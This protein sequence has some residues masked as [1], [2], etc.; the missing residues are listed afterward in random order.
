MSLER[1]VNKKL[2]PEL[3]FLSRGGC[4]DVAPTGD[5]DADN[6]TGAAYGRAYVEAMFHPETPLLCWIV[7]DIIQ[8]GRYTGIEAGFFFVVQRAAALYAPAVPFVT[9]AGS[10]SPRRTTP[11][12]TARAAASER[13][14]D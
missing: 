2:R 7:K 12:I 6:Q 1:N 4:W 11:T 10:A 3:P 5:W 9:D 13:R 8:A 14:N